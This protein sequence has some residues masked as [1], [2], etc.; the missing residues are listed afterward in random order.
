MGGI[1]RSRTSRTAAT[2]AWPS[3]L[4]DPPMRE[5]GSY[6]DLSTAIARPVSGSAKA[7]V[8]P[9]PLCPRV[10]ACSGGMWIPELTQGLN[11]AAR[12]AGA[13]FPRVGTRLCRLFHCSCTRDI[14][15][16]E[17]R[18][19]PV[20]S[21]PWFA[22]APYMRATASAVTNEVEEGRHTRR[23]IC[24]LP[25]MVKMVSSS[26][27]AM[28]AAREGAT[29]K[30]GGDSRAASSAAIR[31]SCSGG[32]RP[33]KR[34][35][36]TL[37]GLPT[38]ST[39]TSEICRPETRSTIAPIIQDQDTKW[40][41]AS[42][43]PSHAG[44]CSSMLATPASHARRHPT[45]FD[46][47][48]RRTTFGVRSISPPRCD[49]ASETVS[50]ALPFSFAASPTLAALEVRTNPGQISD[51]RDSYD[52]SFASTQVMSAAAATPLATLYEGKSVSRS[53]A[54]HSAKGE[55]VRKTP[56]HTFATSSP[57]RYT[58]T[59]IPVCRPLASCAR[60]KTTS[61]ASNS[62]L[63]AMPGAEGRMQLR[64]GPSSST[65]AG[66]GGRMAFRTARRIATTASREIVGTTGHPI[67]P[68]PAKAGKDESERWRGA[69]DGFG[70]DRRGVDGGQS[71]AVRR[72][73]AD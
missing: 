5:Y 70:R 65:L 67:A 17:T 42:R 64:G 50:I 18:R 61:A 57:W 66:P 69:T 20:T 23:H 28:R 41:D 15:S 25:A 44:T 51:T 63:A 58:A 11:P 22:S 36:G 47:R 71:G 7:M 30:N 54:R 27:E 12:R 10:H 35:H 73:R 13:S 34:S 62:L 6:A 3:G 16:G 14:T 55:A 33:R 59:A 60:I 49:T 21:A 4:T 56:P 29:F 9:M 43:A 1:L 32:T 48:W 8:P 40:Y 52:T 39:T 46:A 38:R 26:R 45:T 53:T 68:A 72:R 19:S 37:R 24:V 2:S 31:W